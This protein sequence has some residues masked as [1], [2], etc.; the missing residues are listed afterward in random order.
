MAGPEK[1]AP[2][3]FPK[4]SGLQRTREAVFAR[5]DESAKTFTSLRCLLEI[6]ASAQGPQ[7]GARAMQAQQLTET[8]MREITP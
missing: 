2:A 1:A 6:P 7:G 5:T 4:R 3:L 8:M